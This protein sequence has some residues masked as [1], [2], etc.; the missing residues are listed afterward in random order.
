MKLS[1]ENASL[2]FTPPLAEPTLS[3]SSVGVWFTWGPL[4]CALPCLVRGKVYGL[5]G[6]SQLLHC[7]RSCCRVGGGCVAHPWP[8]E[9]CFCKIDFQAVESRLPI[10]EH[11]R[12]TVLPL[13]ANSAEFLHNFESKLKNEGRH[14]ELKTMK[15]RGAHASNKGTGESWVL[16]VLHVCVRVFCLSV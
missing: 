12:L 10:I 11:F 4:D 7:R 14:D 9:Y 13:T 16:C 1:S 3:Q 2:R 5:L 8:T 15:K 6:A